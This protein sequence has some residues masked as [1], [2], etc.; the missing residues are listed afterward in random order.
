MIISHLKF[1]SVRIPSP[2]SPSGASSAVSQK[3]TISTAQ[4]NSVAD[5]FVKNNSVNQKLPAC[6]SADNLF[7]K[8]ALTCEIATLGDMQELAKGSLRE[9]KEGEGLSGETEKG[10]FKKQI[11]YQR[12]W[13]AAKTNLAEESR[14]NHLALSEALEKY[15]ETIG[16]K[17]A[18]NEYS[19]EEK[20]AALTSIAQ[21]RFSKT[22]KS[23]MLLLRDKSKKIVARIG[24]GPFQA[25]HDLISLGIND[26]I[27]TKH[28]LVSA[29]H[30]EPEYR[31]KG[32]A[33]ALKKKAI[34]TARE[35]LGYKYLHSPTES[36]KSSHRINQ[37]LGYKPWTLKT[38][39]T[40]TPGITPALVKELLD[41]YNIGPCQLCWIDTSA[42]K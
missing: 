6:E 19:L 20:L 23:M 32:I 9:Q 25:G 21:Q 12:K 31:N 5:T 39:F 24:L 11:Q 27:D 38:Q 30:V 37:K 35:V 34:V 40:D 1:S 28:G 4:E 7:K 14:K 3:K 36:H 18:H 13:L 33:T 26:I 17:D 22:D 15:T 2:L 8:L 16:K 29:L 41:N 42:V 10:W